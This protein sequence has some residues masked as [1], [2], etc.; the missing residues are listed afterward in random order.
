MTRPTIL[1]SLLTAALLGAQAPALC[2]E[3]VALEFKFSPGEVTTYEVGVSGG[4]HLRSSEGEMAPMGMQG[5]LSFA[6]RTVEV[7]ADGSARLEARLSGA[8]VQVNIG[9]QSA[10]FA[11]E[12]GQMR[13]FANGQEQA[14]PEVDF[15]QLPL[16]GSPIA[17]TMAPDGRTSALALADPRLLGAL[18][19][20]MPGIGAG[21]LGRI[22]GQ[23]FPDGPVA[24]GETWRE[25]ARLEP[26]GPVAPITVSTARTLDSHDV[27]GGIGIAKISGYSEA[28]CQMGPTSLSR[29]GTEATVAVPELRETITSTEF[30]STSQGRLVRADYDVAFS[31]QFSLGVGEE[32]REGDAEARFHIRVQ[33]R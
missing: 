28:R 23:V 13:W 31:A 12:N 15:S 7:L 18:G 4:G 6:C 24:V 16:L 19:Q 9:E 3:G 1:F 29:G 10:R 25:S 32:E 14:P 20:V 30:F 11:Y 27:Q 22:G 8:N 33:A 26:F 17:F 21:G 5:T 2:Q